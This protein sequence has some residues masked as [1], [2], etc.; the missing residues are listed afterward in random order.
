[1]DSLED[2]DGA[3]LKHRVS[4]IEDSIASTDPRDY[5][6]VTQRY[7]TPLYRL[8][9]DR[10]RR[11][12][13]LVL[14]HSNKICLITLAPSHPVIANRLV[15]NKVN[16]EVSNKVDRKNNK[17]SGKSK[18]G[19]QLLEPTS[20]LAKL[21]TDDRTYKVESVVPGKLI[22]MNRAVVEQPDR[23]ISHSDSE[24]HLAI[25][26]P[27]RGL[28]DQVKAGLLSQEQYESQIEAEERKKGSV[29]IPS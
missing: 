22:C 25:V 2:N 20:I 12:D 26:L 21:E 9:P 7:Y 6:T 23:L 13:I 19:G 14:L 17:T 3:C 27:I 10:N 15:I 28:F 18:K 1:M 16:L 5:L 4:I 24:G 29:M 11:E 8:D